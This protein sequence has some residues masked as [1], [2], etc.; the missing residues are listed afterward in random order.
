MADPLQLLRFG[1]EEEEQDKPRTDV[2]NVTN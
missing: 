2:E 1:K